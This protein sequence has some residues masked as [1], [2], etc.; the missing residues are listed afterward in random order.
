MPSV[1]TASLCDSILIV[2]AVLG[3]SVLVLTIA[4]LK[5]AFLIVG[6]CFLLYIGWITWRSSP[7]QMQKDGKPFSIKR[8]IVFTAS[9]SLLN[10]HAFLDTIGVIGTNSLSFSSNEK[11]AYTIGCIV[12]SY[13][14]FFTLSI[15]GH[16][17]NK[18]DTTGL[19]L[20]LVNK[21]SALIIWAVAIYIGL[22]L[23][24]IM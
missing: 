23:L 19:W 1:L 4:W 3:V 15:I 22:L 13:C 20:S 5:T 21:L 9:V 6:F 18:S 11:L 17:L 24:K 12:M 10:P 14:W 8:Q 2:C 16:Y 7:G